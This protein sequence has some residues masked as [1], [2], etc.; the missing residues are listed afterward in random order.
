MSKSRHEVY[1]ESTRT[2]H[3]TRSIFQAQ[4]SFV[5]RCGPLSLGKHVLLNQTAN[6][7]P[8]EKGAPAYRKYAVRH[9]YLIYTVATH[10]NPSVTCCF[11]GSFIFLC[12]FLRTVASFDR[13]LFGVEIVL[14]GFNPENV[15]RLS[16][17]Y[18]NSEFAWASCRSG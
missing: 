13:V 9:V 14:V 2:L 12:T 10:R 6:S 16:E 18:R 7:T 11:I 3:A 5:S 4:H 1:T 15:W 8:T 17:A